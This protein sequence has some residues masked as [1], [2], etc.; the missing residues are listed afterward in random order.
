[1]IPRPHT[2]QSIFPKIQ[3]IYEIAIDFQMQMTRFYFWRV[4]QVLVALFNKLKKNQQQSYICAYTLESCDRC[5]ISDEDFF[6]LK[7]NGNM[8]C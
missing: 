6:R 4:L 5:G 1:M 2:P 8:K 3:S 7:W